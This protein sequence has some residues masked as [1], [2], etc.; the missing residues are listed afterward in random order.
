MKPVRLLLL[1]FLIYA[2]SDGEHS[3]VPPF[4]DGDLSIEEKI[5]IAVSEDY[6]AQIGL[7]DTTYRF[8]VAYYETRNFKPRW[9]ND[10]TLTETGK[11]LKNALSHSYMIGLPEG[12]LLQ[13]TSENYIQD[14]LN[15]TIGLAQAMVDL[16]HGIIDYTQKK[17]RKRSFVE[18]EEFDALTAFTSDQDIRQQFIRFG[19]RDSVY[20]ILANG[21]IH[22]IDTYPLDTNTFEV[23]SIKTDS[24]TAVEKARL[25]LV[26]KGYLKNEVRDSAGIAE[27]LTRF[28]EENGLKPDGVIGKYTSAA[29]NESTYHKVERILLSMDKI[30][31]QPERP[32]KYIRINIPEYML[33]FYIHDSLKSEHHIVVGKYENQTPELQSKLKKIVVYPYWNVPYS[34]SSKEILPALKSNPNYLAKNNY[35]IYRNGEEV[36]PLTVNWKKIRQDAFPYKVIQQ[37]GPRNSLGILKFDFYNDHSVYFHDTPAK[38]L[39]STDVRAYSHGCMRTQHPVDLA[40]IILDRDV[41]GRKENVMIPDSL[42]SVLARGHN[43]EIRL[44]DPIPVFVEYQSVTRNRKNEMVVYIDIYGRDEE[45][46]KI[47][48]GQKQ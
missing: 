10:T 32:E 28:Q 20:E 33:R 37:P 22:L 8:L 45:Y 44:L 38:A 7:P 30:R 24:T 18:P 17:S 15:I 4:E 9:I 21:L 43:Y 46:L 1:P 41:I 31:S 35:K 47:M 13:G 34:I 27:G 42:D 40:K 48:R 3:E 25:A 5:K 12:R 11:S 16:K 23:K 19:P 2:C 29:L 39:F 6:L 36:D 26:S 14:E